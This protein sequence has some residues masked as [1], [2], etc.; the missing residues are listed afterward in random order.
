[1]I[2]EKFFK[3]QEQI[4][5]LKKSPGGFL[6]VFIMRWLSQHKKLWETP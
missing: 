6:L 5:D 4:D 1:L 2:P 3:A